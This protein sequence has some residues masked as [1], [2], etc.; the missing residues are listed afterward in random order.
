MDF[1]YHS[2]IRSSNRSLYVDRKKSFF[3]VKSRKASLLVERVAEVVGVKAPS[4]RRGGAGGGSSDRNEPP[5]ARAPG[6]G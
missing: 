1:I 6:G 3:L 2:I 4:G 5:A